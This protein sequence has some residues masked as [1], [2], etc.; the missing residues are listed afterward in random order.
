MPVAYAT[1][2]LCEATCGLE[3]AV[4]D[5]TVGRIHTSIAWSISGR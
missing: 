3:L 4:V 2:P 1:C 5:G